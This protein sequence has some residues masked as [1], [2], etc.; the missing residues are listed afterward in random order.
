MLTICKWHLV[1]FEN[2]LNINFTLIH[3]N[4]QWHDAAFDSIS[5]VFTVIITVNAISKSHP[6]SVENFL[7]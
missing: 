4:A 2:I 7:S 5:R 6:I 3:D 1:Y